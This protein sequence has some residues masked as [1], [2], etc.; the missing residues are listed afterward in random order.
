MANPAATNDQ[1]CLPL[2]I[3]GR[4]VTSRPTGSLG[5]GLSS[6]SAEDLRADTLYGLWVE[7]SL[8]VIII[9]I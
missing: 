6:S 3:D 7:P 4:G 2:S 1:A 9:I 5:A 8:R